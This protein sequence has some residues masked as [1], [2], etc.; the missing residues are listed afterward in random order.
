M[1]AQNKTLRRALEGGGGE[2]G[3]GARS[4]GV[5]SGGEGGG[6]DGGNG[7]SVD[8]VGLSSRDHRL[9]PTL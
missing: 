8:V 3:E 5:G 1:H 7:E 9:E 2:A 6:G 4:S